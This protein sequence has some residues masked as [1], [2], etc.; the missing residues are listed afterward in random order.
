MAEQKW[1][2]HF[3][4]MSSDNGYNLTLGGLGSPGWNPLEDTRIKMSDAHKGMKMSP[5]A[6]EKTSSKLRGRKRPESVIAKMRGRIVSDETRIK[7]GNASRGRKNIWSKQAHENVA[8]AARKKSGNGIGAKLHPSLA[9]TILSRR[10]VNET[11]ASIAR[12]YAVTASAIFYF[13]KRN[14][15]AL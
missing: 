9:E 3:N 13:C 12:D 14:G 10:A 8:A 2:K 4:S 15:T 5:E 1:V 7:I 11:F 6:I